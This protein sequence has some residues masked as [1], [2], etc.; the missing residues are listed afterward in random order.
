M[1]AI[2]YNLLIGAGAVLSL[3]VFENAFLDFK[4]L[5]STSSFFSFFLSSSV[6]SSVSAYTD[7][8]DLLIKKFPVF[9]S[10]S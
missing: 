8:A 9:S 5:Y 4:V 7:S 3:S 2:I 1:L 10:A 6:V